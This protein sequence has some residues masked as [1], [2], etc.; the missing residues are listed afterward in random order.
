MKDID[1]EPGSRTCRHMVNEE[2]ASKIHSN[3]YAG[4]HS[5]DY[6]SSME[7]VVRIPQ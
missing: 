4:K 2:I 1:R 6:S 5:L 3:V 7:E